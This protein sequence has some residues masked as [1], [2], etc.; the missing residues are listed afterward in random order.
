[1][2]SFETAL[3]TAEALPRKSNIVG[4]RVE[5]HQALVPGFLG[6]RSPQEGPVGYATVLEPFFLVAMKSAKG[7]VE[8]LFHKYRWE[9]S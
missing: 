1:L 4:V 7:P 3:G 8:G 5:I 9:E 2:D 6:A